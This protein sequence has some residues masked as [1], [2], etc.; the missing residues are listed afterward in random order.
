MPGR[1][2]LPVWEFVDGLVCEVCTEEDLNPVVSISKQIVL[3]VHKR[4]LPRVRAF[5]NTHPTDVVVIDT[6]KLENNSARECQCCQLY[7]AI[8]RSLKRLAIP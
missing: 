8:D 1:K 4:I 6:D 7:C 2:A 5:L 3:H